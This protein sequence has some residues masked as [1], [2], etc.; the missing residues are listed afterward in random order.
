MLLPKKVGPLTLMRKLGSDGAT[1]AFAGILDEPAG[2]PVVAYRLPPSATDDAA[3]FASVQ[4]RVHDLTAVRH[5]LLLPI[6]QILQEEGQTFVIEEQADSV[7][8]ATVLAWCRREGRTLPPNLFLHLATQV[9][10]ALEA[11]HGRPGK[12]T[13]AES[14]LHLALRPAAVRVTPDGRALLGGYDLGVPIAASEERALDRIAA[15]APEQTQAEPD[16]T[17]AADI[18][19]LGSLLYEMLT[20]EPLFR[21]DSGLQTLH[22]V[23][24]AEVSSALQ[25]V[26]RA[27]PGLDK[28]L[29]RALSLNPRH[30]YQRAF[31]L[32][33][34]V[35]GLMAGY[36]FTRIHDD[37]VAFL[38]PVFAERAARVE[39]LP[40]DDPQDSTGA[41][42]RQAAIGGA[43][44]DVA[45]A[46]GRPTGRET[47]APVDDL[48]DGMEI[49]S[50]VPT[51]V[52]PVD[53]RAVP[54]ATPNPS[55]ARAAGP[56]VP[57]DQT[58]WIR[59]DVD[60]PPA[61]AFDTDESTDISTLGASPAPAATRGPATLP[62]EFGAIP[63]KRQLTPAEA[64]E[65]GLRQR[66]PLDGP[67]S[68]RPDP[69]STN[70]PADQR[71]L[72]TAPTPVREEVVDGPTREER[73]KIAAEAARRAVAR[74]DAAEREARDE[75][76]AP[77]RGP[78]PS[79]EVTAPRAAVPTDEDDDVDWR[80]RRS[81][82]VLLYAGAGVGV[83]L[84]LV[85][86][87]GGLVFGAVQV[88]RQLG[89]EGPVAANTPAQPLGEILPTAPEFPEFPE[90]PPADPTT[91]APA[92]APAAPPAAPAAATPPPAAPVAAT[93]P[94]L[95]APT[96]PRAATPP[97]EP[98][99]TAPPRTTTPQV[100]SL[101]PT[102][103]TTTR[104]ATRS[105]SSEPTST[106]VSRY[107]PPTPRLPADDLLG[108]TPVV[109]GATTSAPSSI[110]ELADKA[111][112]GALS[113]ADR[114]TLEMVD[115]S[116]VSYTRAQT[117]LYEDAKARGDGRAQ[118][119]HLESILG[120]PENRYNPVFLAE[121]AHLDIEDRKFDRA[122][123]RAETAERHW[124]RL[125]SDLV[126]SRKA[127]I[128]EAQAAAWQGL[129]YS[130][131]GEDRN[132]LQRS[133]LA[134]ERYQR[135]VGVKNR[136]DM[137]QVADEQLAKLYDARR[138]LE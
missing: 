30:R 75:A 51:S 56:S 33:E 48:D 111:R 76:P 54:V 101:S 57:P 103:P 98:T 5:P 13:G 39:A 122:L 102:T 10:N 32:R 27:M 92:D 131:G 20:L 8:L 81:N 133:I 109:D 112:S 36:S 68:A 34:D 97:R 15:L 85:V 42:L 40:A 138:R 120:H 53:P 7:D 69:S 123:Q 77:T 110:D 46:S 9:C 66:R 3:R 18:F 58:S 100:A 14:V 93:P 83:F 4:S 108:A 60:R 136:T 70:V 126:F 24:K 89:G 125:P 95:V 73:A 72:R 64:A 84:L 47:L 79:P 12:S 62:P 21:G 67:T 50:E 31:V 132:A 38:E 124:A 114:L 17:P 19:S 2:Q 49:W 128:Y 121:G 116:N 129:F 6:A 22:A 82:R 115:R 135:H 45:L 61:D 52:D 23:R 137:A 130:S 59:R 35:R 113:A 104:T 78:K 25:R 80:P 65:L 107:A 88:G 43:A 87:G 94:T 119:K 37:L 105:S 118:R 41:L 26:K 90:E 55:R 44:A 86:C 29:Y 11:L 96:A 74:Q 99:R 91:A 127:M 63:T 134:W 71:D 16:L 28:V 117:M 106:S 1:E